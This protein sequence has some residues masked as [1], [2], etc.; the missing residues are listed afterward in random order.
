MLIKLLKHDFI[1]MFKKISGIWLIL[2]S[3][4]AFQFLMADVL[5]GGADRRF[6]PGVGNGIF[7]VFVVAG[8][9]FV[10]FSSTGRWFSSKM[11]GDEGYLTN[12][13]PAKT[14]Q[15][16]LSKFIIATLFTMLSALF[17]MISLGVMTSRI[18]EGFRGILDIFLA[19]VGSGW[20]EVFQAWFIKSIV[21][22]FL[23]VLSFL[24]LIFFSISLA[25]ALDF[26]NKTV[27]TVV[28][29]LVFAFVSTVLGKALFADTAPI[30]SLST[31]NAYE[32]I[33]SPF[34][35]NTFLSWGYTGVWILFYFFGTLFISEKHLKLR[36]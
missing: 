27:N 36:D 4:L 3:A 33:P 29:I 28:S 18:V 7:M 1:T 31:I 11:Y 20:K 13:L 30:F 25:N 26:G 6:G 12:T 19:I 14:W 2:G 34:N 32:S 16:V 17:S 22:F 15:I 21:D 9:A 5:M 24:S 35:M 10:G 8:F 23:S